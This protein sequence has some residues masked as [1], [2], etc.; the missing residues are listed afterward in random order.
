MSP[1]GTR[2]SAR[3][4]SRFVGWHS[5]N[6]N[7]TWKC[8]SHVSLFFDIRQ[9]LTGHGNARATSRFLLT[10]KNVN[11]MLGKQ[12]QQAKHQSEEAKRRDEMISQKYGRKALVQMPSDDREA[13][14]IDD[15]FMKHAL[16]RHAMPC[17]ADLSMSCHV[18]RVSGRAMP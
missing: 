6:L 14:V 1:L 10:W 5:S 15:C 7:G 9:V 16:S 4:T 11:G 8:A 3:A 17:H 13:H 18:I 2:G 12:L